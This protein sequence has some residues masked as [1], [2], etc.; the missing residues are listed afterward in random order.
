MQVDFTIII[1]LYKLYILRFNSF[2]YISFFFTSFEK[3]TKQY[4]LFLRFP[5]FIYKALK[6]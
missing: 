5:Q 2:K 6:L 4:L 3:I 1:K